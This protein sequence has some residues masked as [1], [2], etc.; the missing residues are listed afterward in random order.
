MKK[1]FI[2]LLTFIMLFCITC[3]AEG[4]ISADEL[5]SVLDQADR[6]V[7][8][9]LNDGSPDFYEMYGVD[10]T[11]GFIINHTEYY[12]VKSGFASISELKSYFCNFMTPETADIYIN[13]NRR[14]SSQKPGFIEHEGK[15][16]YASEDAT[17]YTY[18]TSRE[19]DHYEI[20]KGEG[21]RIVLRYYPC[22]EDAPNRYNYNMDKGLYY[23]YEFVLN[24]DGKY[25]VTNMVPTLIV[26]QGTDA[27][28]SF[29]KDLTRSNPITSDSAVYITAAAGVIALC[30]AVVYKKKLKKV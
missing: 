22:Y 5:F 30:L 29:R 11:D 12:R 15:L 19:T 21:D 18:E 25:I 20:I 28:N 24:A 16:Y 23:D 27:I 6:A 2:V 7:S 1:T 26:Y 13:L 14:N 9:T 3:R 8:W 4:S 10:K 17:L